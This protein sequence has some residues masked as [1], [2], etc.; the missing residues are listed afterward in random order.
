[1]L[2]GC[3]VSV[4]TLYS[5]AKSGSVVSVE[6]VF[7]CMGISIGPGAGAGAGSGSGS[8][9]GFCKD[10]STGAGSGSGFWMG[11]SIGAFF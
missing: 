9:S 7:F 10:I 5:V 11:F 8:G 4:I 3:L 2:G 1:M 6:A